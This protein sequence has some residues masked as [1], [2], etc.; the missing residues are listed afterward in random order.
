MT[1]NDTVT[2]DPS[3]AE[4]TP[5]VT[6]SE[7]IPGAN[8]PTDPS[9]QTPKDKFEGKSPEELKA[10]LLEK[11]KFIGKQALEL[12]D[13]RKKVDT[14]EQVSDAD[15]ANLAKL[16]AQPVTEDTPRE[17]AEMAQIKQANII[18]NIDLAVMKAR[19]DSSMPDFGRVE[20]KVMELVKAKPFLLFSPT[21]TKDAYKLVIADR[22]P[23]LM[24]EAEERG[25]NAVKEN[26]KPKLEASVIASSE[27]IA[28]PPP[29]PQTRED[30][31]NLAKKG[32][33]TME[34]LI[35]STLS[36]KE[37]GK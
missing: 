27:H 28:P 19:M 20:A 18:N 21:W 22:I 29:P 2:P 3:I 14:P 31:I 6:P 11:E 5:G 1:L 26:L 24:T 8:A 36:D 13:L 30:M 17:E 23:E 25:K 37:L 33:M 7:V 34:Q 16:F 32:K 35:L 10:M 12:G 4:D 15:I 9:F